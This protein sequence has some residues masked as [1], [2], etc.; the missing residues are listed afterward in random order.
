MKKFCKDCKYFVINSGEW[1]SIAMQEKYSICSRTGV[2]GT[3][4]DGNYCTIE[5]NAINLFFM[6][7][8]CGQN[9]IFWEA[10]E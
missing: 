8:H 1:K 7:K 10:K 5:R 6:K 4:A 2:I 9:A 3:G